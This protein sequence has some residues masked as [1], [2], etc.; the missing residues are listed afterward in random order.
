MY[1]YTCDDAF[2]NFTLPCISPKTQLF[3]FLRS[4]FVSDR[5][6]TTKEVVK[7]TSEKDPSRSRVLQKKKNINL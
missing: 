5:S 2:M 6:V 3:G 1:V 4:V 7:K